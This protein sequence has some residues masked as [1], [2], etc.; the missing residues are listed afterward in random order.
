MRTLDA[1]QIERWFAATLP[2]RRHQFGLY[3]LAG[4]ILGTLLMPLAAGEEP[5]AATGWSFLLPMSLL[6]AL[7]AGGWYVNRRRRR[8]KRTL[9]RAWEQVQLE[10]WDGAE[11]TL[12]ELLERPIHAASDRCQA[13]RLLAEVAE[14]A[15][16]YEAA[17]QVY[18]T[19][20]LQRIGDGYQLQEV[21][22]ASCAI[23]LRNEELTDAVRLIERL[24]RVPMPPALKAVHDLIRLYQQVFMG[25]FDDAVEK[26]EER[27]KLYRRHLSTRAGYGYGLLAAAMHHLGRREEA[28]RLWADA[29]TLIRADE[30][31][32]SYALLGTVSKDYP[33]TEHP[34]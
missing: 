18:E 3:L 33:A 1:Q 16:Q 17:A 10:D 12:S 5:S 7:F 15:G 6:A 25:H 4:V 30:L 2:R 22:L 31:V 19:L 23:K 8:D 29:T 34:V 20:L 11:A 27:R 14:H 32:R 24:A 26:A 28:S 9:S 13:F 21:Q